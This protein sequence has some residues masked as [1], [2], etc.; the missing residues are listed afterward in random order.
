MYAMTFRQKAIYNF[1]AEVSEDQLMHDIAV[2]ER[3]LA[4][5]GAPAT[6][7]ERGLEKNYRTLLCYGRKLLAAVRDGRPDRWTDYP[8]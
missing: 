8:D 5:L 6:A 2:Y 4:D 7:H 3:A 1:L